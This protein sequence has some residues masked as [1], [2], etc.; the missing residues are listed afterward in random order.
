MLESETNLNKAFYGLTHE[1][2]FFLGFISQMQC[3]KQANRVKRFY[4]GFQLSV[5]YRKV[6]DRMDKL[7]TH[8]VILTI[9]W[10][11]VGLEDDFCDTKYIPKDRIFAIL[12]SL[13]KSYIRYCGTKYFLQNGS[14]SL[15]FNYESF[16]QMKYYEAILTNPGRAEWPCLN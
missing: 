6:E 14:R 9:I 10:Q 12:L 8:F 13:Q 2:K 1:L 4:F 11:M 16:E 3:V 7:K 5:F 15:V